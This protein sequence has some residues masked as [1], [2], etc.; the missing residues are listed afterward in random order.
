MSRYELDP[1]NPE[2]I[3]APQLNIHIKGE[4][5]KLLP[6]N[7]FGEPQLTVEWGMDATTFR[8]GDP[9]ATKYVALHHVIKT[10]VWRR[11][12]PIEGKY[13]YFDTRDAAVN[14]INI[15]LLPH[16]ERKTTKEIRI[17]G[18]PR[19][20]VAQWFPAEMIDSKRNWERN[21][22]GSYTN[23]K[24]ELV[25]FD[26]LGPYPSRGQYREVMMVEGLEG[27]FRDLDA[28]VVFEL[29]RRLAERELLNHND[30]TD[31]Q[32]IRDA[33]AEERAKEA[34]REKLIEEE[35]E[36]EVGVS[37]YRLIEGNAF[38]GAGGTAAQAA[39][40]LKK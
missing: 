36:A 22:I 31:A 23:K 9:K 27:E 1:K 2:K 38:A 28:A 13:E 17:F 18:P 25:T 3:P 11:L 15:R 8:N 26:A 6:L 30:F 39:A 14:A 37:R 40:A 33:V 35:F 34:M 20:F 5:E 19:W 24:R 16:L 7:C 21:R 12:D 10:T 32:Q 29:R 4:I